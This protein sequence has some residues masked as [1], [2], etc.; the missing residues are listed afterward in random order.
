MPPLAKTSWAWACV[1][2]GGAAVP[3]N[4][5]RSVWSVCLV[6]GRTG[7]PPHH[8]P[9]SRHPPRLPSLSGLLDRPSQWA[10]LLKLG[11]ES[12]LPHLWWGEDFGVRKVEGGQRR[13]PLSPTPQC[14]RT[15]ARVC[16]PPRNQ[17]VE[18][19]G[20]AWKGK[21]AGTLSRADLRQCPVQGW[22]HQGQ[23]CWLEPAEEQGYE[24]LNRAAE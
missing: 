22:G 6:G 19:T 10:A 14:P 15:P 2:V 11:P 23:H 4:Q 9:L 16:P 17:K 8:S 12:S 3:G 21:E 20:L 24:A 7:A 5:A 1:V 18:G 13:E